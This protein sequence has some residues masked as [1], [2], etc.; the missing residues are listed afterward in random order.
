MIIYC[1]GSIKGDTKYQKFYKEIID[2]IT[3]IGHTALSE[4]NEE[5]KT[6]V[7][8]TEKQIFKRDIKWIE[9]SKLL[10]A[11]ASGHSLGV[12]F[13][14]SY[15]IYKKEIP[16]LAVINEKAA[17]KSAMIVGCDPKKITVK[18]YSDSDDLKKII[19]DFIKKNG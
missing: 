6:S 16:V 2:Y 7:P 13:E 12:G 1:A 14:I 9:S 4:L 18:N 15:A 5:F 10:I 3:S 19:T 11:E 8:L 17:N